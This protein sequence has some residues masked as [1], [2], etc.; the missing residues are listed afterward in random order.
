MIL[1]IVTARGDAVIPLTLF[2]H[3][4][5]PEVV[6]A[7]IDTGFTGDLLLP[8]TLADWLGLEPKN[9]ARARLADG[10]VANVLG[11]LVSLL[12][13]GIGRDVLALEMGG[14]VLVGMGL[15]RDHR[16]TVDVVDGGRVTIEPIPR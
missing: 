4:G 7:V 12:W 13:D 3:D 8:K 2:S 1:G 9:R 16:L 6:N 15:L 11:Y 5:Q 14:T 10:G